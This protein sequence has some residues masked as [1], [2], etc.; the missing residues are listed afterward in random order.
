MAST[1]TILRSVCDATC[2]KAVAG[3]EGEGMVASRENISD[4]QHHAAVKQDAAALRRVT[5]DFALDG[6][7]RNA[8]ELRAELP[9]HEL[10]HQSA[11][12]VQ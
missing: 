12:Y 9:G 4:S 6:L 11:G 1:A 3:D 2:P 7:E 8:I 5:H 10:A